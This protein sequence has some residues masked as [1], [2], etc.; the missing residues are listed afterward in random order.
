MAIKVDHIADV[1]FANHFL[2]GEA[3]VDGKIT[4]MGS[5]TN[6]NTFNVRF[7]DGKVNVR[8]AS[9]NF[10]TNMF[11]G[12]TL[13][14]LTQTLQA[15]YDT[16]IAEQEEIAQQKA[17]EE[18][19]RKSFKDYPNVAKIEDAVNECRAIIEATNPPGAA[20][21][22]QRLKEIRKLANLRNQLTNMESGAKCFETAK[23]AGFSN[24]ADDNC[25]GKDDAEVKRY[26]LSTIDTVLD[27][28]L[29][30]M[31]QMTDKNEQVPDF[32]HNFDGA[33]LEAKHGNIQAWLARA[34]GIEHAAHS[35][36]S[37]DLAYS[38][39]AEFNVIANEVRKPFE[40]AAWAECEAGVR[41]ECAEKGITDEETIKG[42][43]ENK[44]QMLVL[45]KED[46]IAPLIRKK[47]EGVG[48]FAVYEALAGA[49]RPVTEIAKDETTGRWTVT[50]LT[51]KS[52]KPIMKSVSG[53]DIDRNYAKLVD[54]FMDG[55]IAMGTVDYKTRVEEGVS[56]ATKEELRAEGVLDALDR[57]EHGN[58]SKADLKE[59]VRAELGDA[60]A[61]TPEQF[62]DLF[63]KGFSHIQLT[64]KDD[65]AETR[66]NFRRLVRNYASAAYLDKKNDRERL[67]YLIAR[68]MEVYADHIK[69]SLLKDLD[70]KASRCVQMLKMAYPDWNVKVAKAK[71]AI[72]TTIERL[73]KAAYPD[74]IKPEN[75]RDVNMARKYL[76]HIQF[77][78]TLFT[79]R[80]EYDIGHRAAGGYEV[81]LHTQMNA[82]LSLVKKFTNVTAKEYMTRIGA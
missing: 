45:D 77:N 43:I 24:H 66:Q 8:F 2:Q 33:C 62:D 82:L 15:Q 17:E 12:K 70:A 39:T 54:M 28:F 7:A 72:A 1:S 25:A 76:K 5:T 68:Q 16:W 71:D 63:N 69:A 48:K 4:V 26:V 41:A 44:V 58:L 37:K 52:G 65:K 46:E 19:A 11:R 34:A 50:T 31:A 14:R 49:R 81:N 57:Y 47:L 27:G 60:S 67:A 35:D 79:E 75:Q 42:R 9:G 30:T 6:G 29:Q 40:D 78:G 74:K 51:D 36:E 10:F 21:F 53:M 3:P 22:I 20:V 18:L 38:V 13:S 55:A 73:V 56:F 23:E 64:Q 80:L 61:F 59:L 32:L